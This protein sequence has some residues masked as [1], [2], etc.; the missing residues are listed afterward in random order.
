M[1]VCYQ[2]VEIKLDGIIQAIGTA[3]S[4]LLD[5][6]WMHDQELDR[7]RETCQVLARTAR[8]GKE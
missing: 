7:I 8:E 5:L 4:A 6:E 2:A 1:N 3:S